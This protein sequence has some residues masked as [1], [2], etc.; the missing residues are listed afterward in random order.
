MSMIRLFHRGCLTI[1]GDDSVF[2]FAVTVRSAD[3]GGFVTYPRAIG[4]FGLAGFAIAFILYVGF[5][6]GEPLG[7]IQGMEGQIWLWVFWPTAG[8]MMAAEGS[9]RFA[10]VWGFLIGTF[11]NAAV[12]AVVGTVLAFVHRWFFHSAGADRAAR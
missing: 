6:L 4:L 3:E 8:L 9:G 2:V 5:T 11:S 12:Y 1:C 10:A 7:L